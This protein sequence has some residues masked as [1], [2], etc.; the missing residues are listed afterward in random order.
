M[1]KNKVRDRKRSTI[2]EDKLARILSRTPF[3]DVVTNWQKGFFAQ[4][5]RCTTVQYAQKH[6]WS[7]KEF[8]EELRKRN[9]SGPILS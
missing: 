7:K 8:Q 5:T 4:E 1:S 9:P 2:A 6:G 3:E